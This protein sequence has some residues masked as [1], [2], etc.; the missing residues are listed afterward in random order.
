VIHAAWITGRWRGDVGLRFVRCAYAIPVAFV[1]AVLMLAGPVVASAGMH[2]DSSSVDAPGLSAGPFVTGAGLVWE[3]SRGIVLTGFAGRSKVLVRPDAPNWDNF[4]DLAWFGRD[5]WV[6]ARPSGV[7]A[8]RI[9]GPLRELPLLHKCNPGSASIKPGVLVTQYAVS[10]EHLYAALPRVCLA[11]HGA[12]FGEVVDIDLRSRRWHVLAPMPGTLGYMA[13]S[14]K[15]LA[16]AYWPGPQR[17]TPEPR[18]FVRVLDAATGALV[19]Q[20]TPPPT[21][22]AG[23][24][25]PGRTSGIQLDD[26]GDV[27]V[28]EGCCGA[29][30]GQLAHIA[31]PAPIRRGWWWARAGSTAGHE[32]QLGGDAVLSEGRVAFLSTDAGSPESTTIDVRNLLAGTTKTVVA[33]S[34][35][36]SAHGLALSG[37]ELAWAQQ[38]TVV[39][40]LSGP[41]PSGGSFE[42]CTPV[43]LSPIELASLDLR[44]TPSSPVA[45]HGAPIP[46]KYAN[47]PPCIEA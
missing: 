12:P 41:T 8:G 32:T 43:A 39:D 22:T 2:G 15:Y 19:N 20:I 3:S 25:R 7:L 17:S 33:F 36:V 11:R 16:L 37:N 30:P 31:R 38:S 6:L 18:P 29:P 21:G 35:S 27:L 5:W 4:A 40:V 44:D 13:A 26:N 47:E 45:V 34:G 1:V 23:G 10:G 28:T 9:G 46:P 14:G 42:R 24:G